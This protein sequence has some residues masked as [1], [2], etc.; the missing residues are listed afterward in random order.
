MNPVYFGH[1]QSSL[2][3]NSDCRDG[4]TYERKNKINNWNANILQHCSKKGLVRRV[5]R[6]RLVFGRFGS[7]IG[8]RGWLIRPGS[9]ISM[10]G[11]V[12]WC[13]SIGSWCWSVSWSRSGVSGSFV[14]RGWCL[15]FHWSGV[16]D[17]FYVSG[18]L[19]VC[20]RLIG[21]DVRP[22]SFVVSDVIHLP[23]NAVAISI[24]IRS[25]YVAV[26][27]ALFFSVLS[28]TVFVFYV[29]A[30]TVRLRFSILKE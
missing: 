22:E 14:V 8:G 13:W 27:V 10:W 25:F 16:G 20:S 19:I 29:I 5:F 9:G 15:I 6:S 11:L 3:L 1:E 23:V 26:S 7:R 17:D 30:E 12:G 4:G 18:I 24:P 2:F 28:G 21:L